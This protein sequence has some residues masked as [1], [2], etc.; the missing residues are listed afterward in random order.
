MLLPVSQ[1]LPWEE[2]GL[3]PRRILAPTGCW[4]GTIFECLGNAIS[5]HIVTFPYPSDLSKYSQASYLRLTLLCTCPCQ[6]VR[7]SFCL[8]LSR[9]Y[10][11]KI[12]DHLCK[13]SLLV[14]GLSS[15]IH[16][17]PKIIVINSSLQARDQ[18]KWSD[19]WFDWDAFV[20]S[21]KDAKLGR[22]KSGEIEWRRV[23][24]NDPLWILFSSGTTGASDIIPVIL[25]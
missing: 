18:T 1:H 2:S 12:H 22:T 14:K 8:Q 19:S 9:R 5:S 11:A 13:L 4:N 7:R 23:S 16:V 10:N 20:K 3:V 24:F 6:E 17:Q 15:A 21:G 25:N